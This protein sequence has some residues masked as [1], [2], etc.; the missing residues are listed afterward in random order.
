V[1][2]K[3]EV[4]WLIGDKAV[5]KI[6]ALVIAVII[7]VAAFGSTAY[8]YLVIVPVSTQGKTEILIGADEP[9]TGAW[10]S[11][12]FQYKGG[13]EVAIDMI[14]EAGGVYVAELGRS[15]PMRLIIYD[16]M[17][18]ASKSVTNYEKL[19][20]IDKVDVC[21]GP[22]GSILTKA[23][24]PV[25]ERY[26]MPMI[27]SATADSLFELGYKW[28]FG[29][30]R[31]S[32][33]I[34]QYLELLKKINED[35]NVPA[36]NKSINLA[37]LYEDSDVGISL[38]E[39]ITKK[40]APSMGFNVVYTERYV[41][42]ATDFVAQLSKARD[43]RTDSLIIAGR[44]GEAATILR[45]RLQ[46]NIY[47]KS[48]YV[49]VGPTMPDWMNLGETGWYVYGASY[50]VPSK[51]FEGTIL[52]SRMNWSTFEIQRRFLEK[53]GKAIDDR[54]INVAMHI[55]A[56]A[57]AIENAG[58]LDRYKVR[59]ALANIKMFTPFGTYLVFDDKN[60]WAPEYSPLWCCQVFPDG[61]YVVYP[62]TWDGVQIAE[63]SFVYPM[64]R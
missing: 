51:N 23:A 52:K 56:L 44:L 38:Y 37:I 15:L 49:H 11:V 58:S 12:G 4:N 21:H 57:V 54:G 1:T 63:R 18:D 39:A 28:S 13:M 3:N 35:P 19:I 22:Y 43:A 6:Q 10:A 64:P 9:L 42:G 48:I 59:D 14:N 47:F 17:S 62:K 20:T 24:L 31:T 2:R 46:L 45:Q 16:D 27:H 41:L 36:E 34:V 33:Y 55:F 8:Y 50:Y 7:I 25:M 60:A 61:T 32:Q 29:S 40:F 5:T 53:T 30:F 26:E